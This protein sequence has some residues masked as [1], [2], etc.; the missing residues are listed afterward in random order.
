MVLRSCFKEMLQGR[1]KAIELSNSVSIDA[2]ND[3]LVVVVVVV[4]GVTV[5]LTSE[6][7][8]PETC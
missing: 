5:F 4:V 8:F 1:G 3:M 2:V 6:D 7:F